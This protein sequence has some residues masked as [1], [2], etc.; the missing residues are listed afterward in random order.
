M[1]LE[2]NRLM[3][4]TSKNNEVNEENQGIKYILLRKFLSC[5]SFCKEE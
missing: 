3:V 4:S 2:T 1:T 5:T